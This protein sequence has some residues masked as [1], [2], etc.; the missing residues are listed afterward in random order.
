[1]I[2]VKV[3]G[4]IPARYKSSRFPG[5]PLSLIAGKSLIQRTYENAKQCTRLEKL[6]V[7]TDDERI[8]NHV[9][10]FGG[11]VVITSQNCSTGTDRI[12]E[13]LSLYKEYSD[14]PYV[15]NIQ[16]DEP[17]VGINTIN[18][19][20]ESCI[21]D[22]TAS[23]STA[24]V[25]CIDEEIENPSVVKC[26]FNNKLYAMYF[27]R[28]A[29]PYNQKKTSSIVYYRH[30]GIYC[31]KKDFLLQYAILSPTPLQIAEDL[32]QLKIIEHGY[33]IKVTIVNDI[34][35]GVDTPEDIQK[36]ENILEK[37]EL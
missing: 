26:I 35:V 5:K 28:Y 6:I 9:K 34:A 22:P 31:Y 7:A 11:E 30:I 4:I 8:Y 29:I 32:E 10:S 27:S 12:V 19:T 20:I 2:D 23:V 3:L 14:I 13:A 15:V 17:C 36:V 1:M 24:V 21:A 25:Q 33:T 37:K 16:G 18:K